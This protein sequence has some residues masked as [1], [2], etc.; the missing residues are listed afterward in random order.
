M[1]SIF[2]TTPTIQ[3]NSTIPSGAMFGTSHPGVPGMV[4]RDSPMCFGWGVVLDLLT[5]WLKN[6]DLPWYNP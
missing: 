1:L 4:I 5:W 3:L 2:S 6:G